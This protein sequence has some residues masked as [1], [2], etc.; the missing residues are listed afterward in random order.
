MPDKET[1]QFEL[2]DVSLAARDLL[3]LLKVTMSKHVRVET[4]FSKTLPAVRANPTQIRQIVMNLLTNASE[5]IG[6]RE[7]VIRITTAPMKV[8]LDSPLATCEHPAA[9]SYI[10][11]EVS[12][13][14]QG[15]S[16]EVQ[17][18]IFELFF[19][20]KPPGNHGLGLA[21]VQRIVQNLRGT[22][23]LSST[24]G[25]GTTFQI[26][27]PCEEDRVEATPFGA[28]VCPKGGTFAPRGTILVVDDEDLLRQGISKLLQRRGFRFLKPATARPGWICSGRGKTEN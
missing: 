28:V 14:G 11:L 1:E 22:I 21:I 9:G 10:Q 20:T 13:D 16:P 3:E 17:A 19:T 18:R 25:E 27:L 7:G 23:R 8:D 15:M 6:D 26:L 2:I 5:A 24:V 12:D 4:R